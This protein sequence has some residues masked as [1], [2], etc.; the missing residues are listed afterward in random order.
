[1]S[2]HRRD[3]MAGAGALAV[4]GLM[5]AAARAADR[6]SKRPA[7]AQRNFTSPAIEAEIARVKAKIA[8][9]ELAWLFE[10]CYPNT[11]DTTVQ[12]GTIDGKPDTFVLTGDIEAMWLRDSSAQVQPYV[13]LV[14]KDAKLKRLFQGLIQRQARCILIDPYANAFDKDP[15][16]PS[17]LEWSQTDQTEM[18]PGVAER[19][20]EIDSL[21]YPMRL[22]HEY[23]KRTRDKAPFDNIWSRAMALAVETFR[24]QQRKEGPGPYHFQRKALAPTDSLMLGG[25]GSPTKKIGLIHSMFRPSD[26]ACLYPFLI[27]SN[28]FAVSA[29][30]Q[31]AT[32]QREAR[33]D[34]KAAA[35]AEALAAEVEG[36]LKQHAL[37]PDGA[38][39]QVWAY[40]IDGFGNWVFMDDAN[41]PSLSGLALIDAADRNDPLFRRTAALAWSERNP[42][43][44][45]GKAAEGIGGPHIGLDMIWP[46]SIITR[47]MNADDD[48][49]ILQCLRWLK[50]THGGTGFMHESFNKDDPTNFTR[51]WF[52]WANALFGQLIVEIAD[53]RPALLAQPL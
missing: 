9:P 17:R 35:E 1:M 27:P 29:L 20:W 47:A 12:T 21:C 38:G 30:R 49:T 41:V 53:K 34:A 22:S 26:D 31:M 45:S 3:V 14:A 42:Y 50:T 52:A 7:P 4:A 11:L 28:L 6:V 43:F 2:F 5:P 19:K 15:T 39:G 33:G 10:N 23:W 48:A 24:V 37:V 36:V 8:D 46:M 51:S 40:E 16:A 13:H 25:Y 32:V 44:F 18:K